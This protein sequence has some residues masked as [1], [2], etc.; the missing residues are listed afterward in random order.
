[1]LYVLTLAGIL[2]GAVLN[3]IVGI[4]W[5]SSVTGN[6]MTAALQMCVLP[7]IITDLIKVLLALSIGPVL[8]RALAKNGLI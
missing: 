6:T 5:F 3:Y 1:M 2:V 4:V 7:F 8:N